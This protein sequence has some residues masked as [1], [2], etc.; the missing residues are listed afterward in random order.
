MVFD[1][2]LGANKHMEDNQI[3]RHYFLIIVIIFFLNQLYY[4]DV[5]EYYGEYDLLVDKCLM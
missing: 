5:E 2:F 4:S 3:A 1:A